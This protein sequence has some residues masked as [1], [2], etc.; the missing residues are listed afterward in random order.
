M[1]K[2]SDL[3]ICIDLLHLNKALK[4]ELHPLPVIDDV[5]TEI[6]GSHV[7]SKFDLRSNCMHDEE[8]RL[9]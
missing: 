8:S 4:R 3:R 7:F 2:N 5:L 6:T 1:K 9:L